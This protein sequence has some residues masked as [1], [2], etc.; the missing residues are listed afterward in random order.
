MKIYINSAKENWIVDR[1]KK[2]WKKSNPNSYTHFSS[3]ADIVWL[4]APWT[5]KKV[6]T[7][8]L[9]SKKVVCSIYHIDEDKFTTDDLKEFKDRDV[10]IDFYHTI[11]TKSKIQLQKLTTK[12]IFVSPFWVNQ[13]I[14]FDI[15]NT[16][17]LSK[18]LGFSPD[19]Y[20]IGS[21]QR[22]T[23]GSDLKSPKLSKGPDRFIEIVEHYY[24]LNPDIAVVLTGK[25]RNYVISQLKAKKIKFY[26]FEMVDFTKLNELYNCLD[27]YI[28]SSRFEGGPQAI[29]E[30][31]ITNTPVI[32]TDVGIASEILSK[33]SIYNM[34][35]FY[36]AKPNTTKAYQNVTKL[37]LPEGMDNFL[38][39]FEEVYES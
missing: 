27:L 6:N 17:N 34:E 38:K 31:A 39:Y 19:D 26:Y 3:K 1:I 28:V 37:T 16:E 14:F 10:Y 20:L 11:S 23:E 25:R 30:C 22:D 9:Q 13:N 35:N 21:F 24:K 5:W 4:L 8:T 33:E 7:K 18:K 29:L 32:S 15:P 12:P 2:E 36:E